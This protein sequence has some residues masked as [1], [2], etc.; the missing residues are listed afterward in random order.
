MKK[1]LATSAVLFTLLSP[2]LHAELVNDFSCV[3]NKG[4][5][6]PHLY[7][8]QQ[9]WMAAA[10][11]NDFNLEA[12]KTRIFFPVYAEVMTTD[13]MVFLWR[14]Q[15]K[16]GAVWGRMADWFLKSEWPGKLAQVMNCGKGSL[17]V[18]PQ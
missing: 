12:Y 18:A 9:A 2:A 7:A 13:P 14:G 1:L 6:V 10:K 8:F 4:Y 16:D 17:W 3:L 11:K 15:F 5:T